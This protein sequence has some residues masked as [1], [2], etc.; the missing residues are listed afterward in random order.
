MKNTCAIAITFWV[1]L[2]VQSIQAATL[3]IRNGSTTNIKVSPRW[4]GGPTSF[5]LISPGKSKIFNSKLKQI[6]CILWRELSDTMHS[7]LIDFKLFSFS[8]KRLGALNMG[9]KLQIGPNG[10]YFYD[11]GIQGKGKGTRPA[12]QSGKETVTNDL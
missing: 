11:F 12:L 10:L 2:S 4:K 6:D 9:A 1:I 3:K 7:G 5:V 8:I